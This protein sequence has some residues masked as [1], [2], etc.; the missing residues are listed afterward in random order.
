MNPDRW[1][2][3]SRIFQTALEHD[4]PRA[5]ARALCADTPD[6]LREVEALLDA[7]E[8]SGSFLESPAGELVSPPPSSLTLSEGSTLGPYLITAKIG[9]GGMGEVFRAHDPILDRDVALKV[10]PP[11]FTK[12][13][14]RL[15][16]FEREAKVLASLDQENI[17]RIYGFERTDDRRALVLEHVSGPTLQDRIAEGPMGLD[18]ALDIA[19]Q[20]A[21]ALDAAHDAGVVHRDLKPANIKL[22]P[23]GTVKVLD[24]GLA[25][26]AAD[27]HDLGLPSA[28]TT[29]VITAEPVRGTA[30]YMSPEQA[31]G[32]TVDRRT[33]VWAF[34]CILFEMLTGE[35]AFPG[36][37]FAEIL[38]GVLTADV[39]Y[40]SL[41][42][43][44]PDAIRRLLRR[45]LDRDPR[46]RL[47]SVADGLIQLEDDLE[48]ETVDTKSAPPSSRPLLAT[49]AV[50][51]TLL[52]VAVGADRWL[53][54]SQ[55]GN[56]DATSIVVP[57]EAPLI[58]RD[59]RNVM[60]LSPDGQNLVYMAGAERVTAALPSAA[61]PDRRSCHWPA[62]TVRGTPCS[63]PTVGSIAF[64][65]G[66]SR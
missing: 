7:H 54:R 50:L 60:A 55:T 37:S 59:A 17:G 23:D 39:R 16:R 29:T 56:R 3:V 53:Q 46:R 63:R 32:R 45:C 41:S 43:E 4:E 2:E 66:T 44:T 52:I 24:F 26:M 31:Q 10:L 5:L 57:E 18:D 28:A 65:V 61:P 14:E 6:M 30:P 47:R 9:E 13:D 49:G 22:R 40:E 20:M 36:D 58:R 48:R 12:H 15:A 19:R 25:T 42:T 64:I 35:R 62:R 34:G 51:G 1:R 11:A 21:E 38:A 8:R 27:G 33:D